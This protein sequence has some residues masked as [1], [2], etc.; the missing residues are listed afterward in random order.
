MTKLSFINNN[1]DDRRITIRTASKGGGKITPLAEV[2][3]SYTLC[4]ERVGFCLGPYVK[5][6]ELPTIEI[7]DTSLF[8]GFVT[9]RLDIELIANYSTLPTG[10]TIEPVFKVA[11]EQII[12]DQCSYWCG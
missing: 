6:I 11:G 12:T 1:P 5:P 7:K 9:D 3:N 2:L 10:W 8:E 4:P